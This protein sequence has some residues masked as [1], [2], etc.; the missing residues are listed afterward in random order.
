ML[1]VQPANE[2]TVDCYR[3]D[4]QRKDSTAKNTPYYSLKSLDRNTRP[5]N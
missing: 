1:A 2:P 3:V 4:I 5:N